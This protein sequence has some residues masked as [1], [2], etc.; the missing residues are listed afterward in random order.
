MD[1]LCPGN[2]GCFQP[3]PESDP[4]QRDVIMITSPSGCG[5]SY[6][7]A[8][9]A[10]N[11]LHAFE[12]SR[13]VIVC[14][15]NSEKD[16]AYSSVP[17]VWLPVEELVDD[18]GNLLTLEDLEAYE[19]PD[20]PESDKLKTLIIFDDVENLFSKK[21]DEI[22]LRFASMCL[23]R[24]RKAGLYI[25]FILHRAACGLL[26]RYLLQEQTAVVF[27]SINHGS[28]NLEYALTKHMGF[29]KKIQKTIK[30]HAEKFG[31]MV[32]IKTASVHRY[33]L[34]DKIIALL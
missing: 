8:M 3:W 34:S 32:Y 7:A 17:H 19:D 16:S 6:Y 21:Q 9:Y 33:V 15:D 18:E 10:K 1:D 27:S 5:K 22:L 13:C 29:D 12:K 14:P 2:P 31:R 24:G 26:S 20:D 28:A 4:S 23:Q 11:F 30:S 25:C